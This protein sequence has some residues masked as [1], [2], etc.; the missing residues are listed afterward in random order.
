MLLGL[1]CVLWNLSET[2]YKLQLMKDDIFRLTNPY[3][4]IKIGG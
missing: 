1:F 4:L 2:N 3:L